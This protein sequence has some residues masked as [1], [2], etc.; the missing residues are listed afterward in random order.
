MVKKKNSDSDSPDEHII[1]WVTLESIFQM[2]ANGNKC[3]LRP[4]TFLDQLIL[5]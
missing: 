1:L 2:Q 3:G 4:Q 5:P